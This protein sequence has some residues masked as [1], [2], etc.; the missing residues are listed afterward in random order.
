WLPVD[1]ADTQVCVEPA[2]ETTPTTITPATAAPAN[3]SGASVE[4]TSVE[5]GDT[6]AGALPNTGA[7]DTVPLA[8]VGGACIA[9]GL[10]TIVVSRR[11]RLAS[12]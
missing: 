2:A 12:E 4:G 11:R 7:H 5:N 3:G 9:V 6:A 10:A 1:R 8:A